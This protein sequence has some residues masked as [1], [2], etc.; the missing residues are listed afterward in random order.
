MVRI[1]KQLNGGHTVR[2]QTMIILLPIIRS[3]LSFLDP[4]NTNNKL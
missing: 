2:E 3:Y 4:K 1:D